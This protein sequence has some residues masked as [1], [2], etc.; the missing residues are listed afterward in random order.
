MRSRRRLLPAVLAP[1]L[2]LLAACGGKKSTEK[3]A[4]P[5]S[6]I[7]L[8]ITNFTVSPSAAEPED[9]LTLSGTI[10]NK[11]TETANPNQGDSFLVRFNLST[12]GTMQLDEQGFLLTRITNP[13]PPGGSVQFTYPDASFPNVQ[14][15][16]GDTDQKYGIFCSQG[17]PA[18]CSPPQPGVLG[19]KV[20][21]GNTINELNEANNYEFIPFQVV[22]TQVGASS[23]GCSTSECD[24]EV[25]DDLTTVSRQL[26]CSPCGDPVLLPNEIHQFIKVTMTIHNCTNAQTPSGGSCGAGGTITATTNNPL[27]SPK[28]LNFSIPCTASY[29]DGLTKGC[30]WVLQIR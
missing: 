20:D 7:D 24:L 6:N 18:P 25:T 19:V 9:T 10:Q 1:L 16:V 17:P 26:P 8:A 23:L 4:P 3:P 28:I 22:G 14:Y 2:V 15:G 11:G 21:A 13:I 29:P 5:P 30:S 12:N 27:K